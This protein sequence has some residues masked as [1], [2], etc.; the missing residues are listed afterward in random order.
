MASS[1][2]DTPS[3]T[4]GD[5]AN[6]GY[7][8]ILLGNGDARIDRTEASIFLENDGQRFR[9]VS[10]AAGLPFTGKGHGITMAVWPVMAAYILLSGPVGFIRVICSP[11][12]FF[13]H[14]TLAAIT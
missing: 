9:N 12:R 2:E 5:A 4:V 13:A 11:P 10:F 7:L 14:N 6:N 1:E 8:D 3:G